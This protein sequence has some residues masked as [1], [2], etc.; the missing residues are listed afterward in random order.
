MQIVWAPLCTSHH[1]RARSQTTCPSTSRCCCPRSLA[2]FPRPTAPPTT[3]LCCPPSTSSPASV[4]PS[5]TSSTSCCPPSVSAWRH[6]LA[7]HISARSLSCAPLCMRCA[8]GH[9]MCPG[10][11][12]RAF[13][14]AACSPP[15]VDFVT[16][17]S[18]A[19]QEVHMAAL[20][21]M[22]R[23]LPSI[24][25]TG[26]LSAV[27]HPLIRALTDPNTTPGERHATLFQSMDIPATSLAMGSERASPNCAAGWPCPDTHCVPSHQVTLDPCSRRVRR[28]DHARSGRAA[29]CRGS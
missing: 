11:V 24:R 7:R 28:G 21:T 27:V 13:S 22:C 25:L 10:H 1:T 26:Y 6:S 3:P 16:P 9:A 2:S 23:V 4:P 15:A 5:R 29:A 17:S 20:Q 14:S 8:L 12:K 18:G 19:P